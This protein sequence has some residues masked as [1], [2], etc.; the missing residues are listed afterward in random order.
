MFSKVGGGVKVDQIQFEK[1]I[2]V[3][4]Q[5]LYFCSTAPLIICHSKQLQARKY[6]LIAKEYSS[7]MLSHGA[8]VSAQ[9]AVINATFYSA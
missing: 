9:T 3:T 4:S 1:A 2:T 6:F 8:A 5:H 7:H